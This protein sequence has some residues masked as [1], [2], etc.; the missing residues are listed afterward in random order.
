MVYPSRKKRHPHNRRGRKRG[1]RSLKQHDDEIDA[2]ADSPP[3]PIENSTVSS[4][5]Q[6]KEVNGDPKATNEIQ[7]DTGNDRNQAK[8]DGDLTAIN[9]GKTAID[10]A[11]PAVNV[12]QTANTGQE[13]IHGKPT[14]INGRRNGR[15][16]VV[17]SGDACCPSEPKFS[18][19][20]DAL[21]AGSSDGTVTT[22]SSEPSLSPSP[23]QETADLEEQRLERE[24]A[25]L[26]KI[27]M[28]VSVDLSRLSCNGSLDARPRYNEKITADI[29]QFPSYETIDS[30]KPIKEAVVHPEL[31]VQEAVV[32]PEVP[33]QEAVNHSEVLVQEAVGHPE[34]TVQEAVSHLE[35]PAEEVPV[36]EAS[37]HLEVPVTVQEAVSHPAV[38]VQEAV[39]HPEVPVQEAV[40]HPEVTVQEAVSHPEVTVQEA[41]CHPEVPVQEALVHPEV[42]VQELEAVS[43]LEVPVQEAV[44]HPDVAGS[45]PDV[46]EAINHSEVS[47]QEA[48]SHLEPCIREAMSLPEVPV[49]NA[50]NHLEVPVQEAV[51]LSEVTIQEVPV[52]EHVCHP[53]VPVQE[54][55]D[56]IDVSSPKGVDHAVPSNQDAVEQEKMLNPVADNSAAMLIMETVC[57]SVRQEAD[58]G[59]EVS[60]QPSAIAEHDSNAEFASKAAQAPGGSSLSLS[61]DAKAILTEN[62]GSTEKNRCCLPRVKLGPAVTVANGVFGNLIGSTHTSSSSVN[63]QET[64][65][66]GEAKGSDEMDGSTTQSCTLNADE[67][68]TGADEAFSSKLNVFKDR[69]SRIIS[70]TEVVGGFSNADSSSST[71]RREVWLAMVEDFFRYDLKKI[72]EAERKYFASKVFSFF[73]IIFSY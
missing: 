58:V 25:D 38:T 73:F 61:E 23:W 60:N 51:H 48:G 14:A 62:D 44:S 70:P 67:T 68:T 27:P 65:I 63:T 13:S 18:I 4:V 71:Q 11:T 17:G 22:S 34:V 12:S 50:A 2:A 49:Q 21:L 5:Q 36:Q 59:H 53:K 45:Y 10:V 6:K 24:T 57:F 72:H 41:V 29:L 1:R 55:V 9:I 47:V 33:A 66:S 69:S 32:H 42:P 16:K 39:S 37:C 35:V 20:Y 8:I 7:I 15:I 30:E 46:Q 56:H 31:L 52:L 19:D 43:H 64:S 3:S 40:S 26:E 28:R 54:A